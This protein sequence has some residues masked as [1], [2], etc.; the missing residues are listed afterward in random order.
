MLACSVWLSGFYM[1]ANVFLACLLAVASLFWV[2]VRGFLSVELVQSFLCVAKVFF[3]FFTM[4][5][6]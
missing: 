2:V 5:L 1:G 4:L 6:S 3:M